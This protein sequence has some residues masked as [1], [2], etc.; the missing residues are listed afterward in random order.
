MA[1]IKKVVAM[2]GEEYQKLKEKA[3]AY[4]KLLAEQEL[5]QNTEPNLEP[6]PVQEPETN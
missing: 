4:D 6:E 3:E 2:T 5:Q 1:T